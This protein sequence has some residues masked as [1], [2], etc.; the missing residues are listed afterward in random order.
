MKRIDKR[1]AAALLAPGLLLALFGL[2]GGGWLWATLDAPERDTLA[3]VLQS[4][5]MLLVLVGLALWALA[6]WA[7]NRLYQS[8]VA[9]AAQLLELA[10]SCGASS[11]AA[12]AIEPAGSAVLR[13]IA[14]ALNDLLRQ[15]AELREQMTAKVA[16][17]ARHIDQERAR[18]AALMAELTQAVVVCNLDGRILLYNQ[19][20]RE[21][22]S[23]A[24][25]RRR[26]PD[27][28][29]LHHHARRPVAARADDAGARRG[30]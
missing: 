8:H 21:Y 16:E 15:R 23:A 18:L 20:A 19:R 28:A 22:S 1:L 9:T 29:V 3:A 30:R 27:R 12:P 13:G 6:A 4:R 11:D 24:A 10:R 14:Q 26:P 2:G 17:A 5:G 25:A 7:L